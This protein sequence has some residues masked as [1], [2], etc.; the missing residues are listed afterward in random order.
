MYLQKMLFNAEAGD[1]SAQFDLALLYA[2][3][4][5]VPRNDEMAHKWLMLAVGNGHHEALNLYGI[6]LSLGEGMHKNVE[7]A[8]LV[9]RRADRNGF[10]CEPVYD[11]MPT[12]FRDRAYGE[13]YVAF[14]RGKVKSLHAESGKAR[15]EVGKAYLSGA[16]DKGALQTAREML[17]SA[18]TLGDGDAMHALG[19]LCRDGRGV[20]VSPVRAHMWF[21]LAE[22]AGQSGASADRA[23]MSSTFSGNDAAHAQKLANRWLRMYPISAKAA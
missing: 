16:G 22:L 20:E 18:A 5:H 9:F 13:E 2:E 11:D 12:D 8:L 17:T 7:E 15:R 10:N 3:G 19:V 14:K 1:P 4:H 6:M 21:Y 23:A